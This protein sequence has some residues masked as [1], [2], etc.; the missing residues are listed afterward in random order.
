MSATRSAELKSIGTH[1]LAHTTLRIDAAAL[2]LRNP[3]MLVYAALL[4]HNQQYLNYT[5]EAMR[6]V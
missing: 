3:S 6:K 1:H 2:C 4:H 5:D